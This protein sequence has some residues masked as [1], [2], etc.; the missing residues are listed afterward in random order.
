MLVQC[1]HSTVH[2]PACCQGPTTKGSDHDVLPSLGLYR[3]TIQCRFG[4]LGFT[5]STNDLAILTGYI[6]HGSEVLVTLLTINLHNFTSMEIP[7]FCNLLPVTYFYKSQAIESRS[8][9]QPES[10]NNSTTSHRILDDLQLAFS[11]VD[12]YQCPTSI[13]LEGET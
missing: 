10:N 12:T 4:V 8:T 7:F 13:F 9:T 2:H 5:R 1:Y 3:F 11:Q 6:M